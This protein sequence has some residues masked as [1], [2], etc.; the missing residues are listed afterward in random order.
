MYSLEELSDLLEKSI[1]NID[2][3]VEPKN[4][5]EPIK[6]VL[7]NKGKRIRPIFTLTACNLF[8]D[9]VDKAIYPALAVEVFHNFTLVHDDIMDCATVRRG[10]E[11]VHRKWNTNTAI[12]SGDVMSV[13]AYQLLSKTNSEYLPPVIE[14][15]NNLAI[16]VCEGQQ[17]DMDF[18]RQKGVTQEEYTRMI[19]LKTAILLK[20]ALQIGAIIG[21]ANPRDIEQIGHFGRNLGLAFQHQDDLLDIYGDPSVFGKKVGGD[22]IS[23]KKTILTVLAFAR[24]QG[25]N[26]DTLNRMYG[27][28]DIDPQKKVSAVVDIFNEEKVKEDIEIL[29]TDYFGKAIE[30]LEKIEVS[31]HRKEIIK[32]LANSIMT[33]I[34]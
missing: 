27:T 34:K 11:T 12:L 26:L 5:Y 4:L 25:R 30:S 9:S 10:K 13:I 2:F 33:R 22:I 21:G 24:A 6:Y 1:T 8:S 7:S 14:V 28:I 18:E 23:N 31:S 3:P 20:G 32:S 17:Y 15:F 16:G 19:E 29:I